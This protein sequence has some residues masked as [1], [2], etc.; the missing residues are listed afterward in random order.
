MFVGQFLYFFI[1][2][3]RFC[4]TKPSVYCVYLQEKFLKDT[5]E[6]LSFTPGL[7]T[8]KFVKGL[9]TLEEEIANTPPTALVSSRHSIS[10]RFLSRSQQA[11]MR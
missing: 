8:E 2:F 4:F 3:L 1:I 11:N 10:A 5:F 9:D 7:S 6:N